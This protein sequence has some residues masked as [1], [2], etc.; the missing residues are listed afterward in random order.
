MI[1]SHCHLDLPAFESDL[2]SV[3]KQSEDAG[4]KRFLVPGTTPKGWKRQLAIRQSFPQCDLAFGHHPYFLTEIEK[5]GISTLKRWIKAHR[6]ACIALGE[7]GLDATVN[8]PMETQQALFLAQLELAQYYELPVILH[9]RKTHH[10]LIEGLKQ[11]KFAHGGIIHAFSGSMQVAQQY[12]EMGF[13]LGIGGTITY[14]RARKTRQAVA[15]LSLDHMVLETDSPDMPMQ[16]RQGQRNAP[17]YIGDVAQALAELKTTS[18]AKVCAQTT[19][20]YLRLFNL[21]GNDVD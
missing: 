14:P 19:N 17:A 8:T 13:S 21:E 4:V 5:D 10:L 18:K 20:N 1:D 12:I 16:G 9:H 6:S 2:H 11:L 15:E 3:V 7:I